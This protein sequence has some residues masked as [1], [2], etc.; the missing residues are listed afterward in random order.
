MEKTL[1]NALPTIEN[2][3]EALN[4]TITLTENTQMTLATT[5]INT[6][7]TLKQAVSDNNP[8]EASITEDKEQETTIIDDNLI[9]L[10][11]QEDERQAQEKKLNKAKKL[12]QEE[13]ARSQASI[14]ALL[15][16]EPPAFEKLPIGQCKAEQLL[17]RVS[18]SFSKSKN[19]IYTEYF[20][21]AGKVPLFKKGY[22]GKV[23]VR[24]KD[25]SL[26]RLKSMPVK[27]L[28]NILLAAQKAFVEKE[29]LHQSASWKKQSEAAKMARTAKVVETMKQGEINGN[30]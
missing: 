7:N 9:K 10:Q 30:K 8:L 19:G 28:N 23:S 29:A 6:D 16:I 5:T 1:M 11:A 21:L 25:A 18:V 24:D 27:D 15:G 26:A 2:T 17:E 22:N 12:Q 14:S 4:N 3:E 20:S 13:L